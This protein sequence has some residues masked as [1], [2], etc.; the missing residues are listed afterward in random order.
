MT[1]TTKMTH[2]ALALAGVLAVAACDQV[3]T[4]PAANDL[5]PDEQLELAV[6]EDE[7]S[8]DLPIELTSVE[9]DVAAAFGDRA[10][11][12]GRDLMDRARLKFL[13]ARRA[14]ADCDYSPILFEMI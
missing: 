7:G 9:T 11:T 3:G 13:S 10:A 4:G 12:D 6:L 8:Y 2:R 1:K 5:T 14:L